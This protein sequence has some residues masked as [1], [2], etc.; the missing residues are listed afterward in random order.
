MDIVQVLKVYK[1]IKWVNP[2]VKQVKDV[3]PSLPIT[4][5]EIMEA[6]KRWERFRP[7]FKKKFPEIKDGLIESPITEATNMKEALE[8]QFQSQINGRLFLK[9]DDSL[10]IAGSIKARGGIYEVITYAEELAIK[11][12]LLHKNDDYS[13]LADSNATAFFSNY[14]LAVGSTGNLGISIGMIG[15]ALGFS[16]TVHM[17]HD[18]KEWKKALL[19]GKGVIVKEYRSDY[20]K[21]VEQGRLQASLDPM[22]Y[23]IDDERSKQLF[24]GYSTAALRL[25]EQLRN[26]GII[27][28]AENPLIVYLPCGVGG[29]PGGITFGLKHVFG[30][31]VK[32]IWVEP[33]HAPCMLLG[34]VTKQEHQVCVQD[35]GI[36]NVTEADGLAVG[37]PS[38]LACEMT[39]HLINGICTIEDEKLY[40]LL[41]LLTDTENVRIEPSA[42]ASLLG[43]IQFQEQ[44]IHLCWLTG[45]ALVPDEEMN[46]FYKRGKRGINN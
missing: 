9:R 5:E 16:V 7:F 24:L 1:E 4:I 21:A 2:Y 12:G 26:S 39:K 40:T 44:G 10:P 11:A 25:K 34:L 41:S 18:A 37:R 22:C 27:I 8:N 30:D 14:S 29:A 17:S 36:D 23:F 31:M 38:P 13:K 45:G 15:A 19:R 43:P 6:E 33:T 28:T 35:Y 3:L 42:A 32:C 46:I 20:S